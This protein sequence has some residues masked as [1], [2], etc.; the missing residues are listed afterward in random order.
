[1]G[2]VPSDVIWMAEV[3][4]KKSNSKHK[5]SAIIY[6]NGGNIIGRGYNRIV[7]HADEPSLRM[8]GKMWFSVH[9]EAHAIRWAIK[10]YGF[11]ALEGS[12]IYVHRSNGKKAKPCLHC[13][14]IIEMV[15]IKEIYWSE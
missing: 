14:Q 15:G 8:Y 13:Q 5:M 9:A 11:D 1:M 3:L 12:S 7:F 6:T 2:Q 10:K 4:C